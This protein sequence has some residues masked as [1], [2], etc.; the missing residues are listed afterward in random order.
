MGILP[1]IKI[2]E[3]RKSKGF[4]QQFMSKHLK[5]SQVSYSKIENNK[6]QL[7]WSKLSK[8]AEI[9]DLNV[10][11]LIDN[12]KEISEIQSNNK[13]PYE[14]VSLLEQ[15]FEKHENQ[16]KRQQ[17]EIQKLKKQLKEK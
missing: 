6:T 11:D 1:Y 5:I 15:L 7:N 12:T 8:I 9:L 16:I 4:S 13:L 3:I 2:R 10:W 14:V 17:E